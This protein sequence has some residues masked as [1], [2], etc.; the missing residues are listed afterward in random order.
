MSRFSLNSFP[1]LFFKVRELR[2][3]S[4]KWNPVAIDEKWTL[5]GDWELKYT[6]T[7][8]PTTSVPRPRTQEKLLGHMTT[9]SM[10]A[11]GKTG[12]R[13]DLVL[14]LAKTSRQGKGDLPFGIQIKNLDFTGLSPSLLPTPRATQ[15]ETQ[16]ARTFPE[17]L[18]LLLHASCA[19][20]AVARV[21]VACVC[22]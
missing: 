15:T 10:T 16:Q 6:F 12:F 8:K 22:A 9:A 13:S 18:C 5:H 3:M 7:P 4:A 2:Y 19:C 1:P 21:C 17:M 14:V 20:C 11:K